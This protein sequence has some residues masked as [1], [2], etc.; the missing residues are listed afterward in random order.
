VGKD[1]GRLDAGLR[2]SLRGSEPR[3]QVFFA[4][5][6]RDD[7]DLGVERLAER[8]EESELAETRGLGDERQRQKKRSHHRGFGYRF[9]H[10]APPPGIVGSR[11]KNINIMALRLQIEKFSWFLLLHPG[12]Q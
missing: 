7:F 3:G 11:T 8:G 9:E 5:L 12:I 4:R 1:S 2:E 6:Q 10:S